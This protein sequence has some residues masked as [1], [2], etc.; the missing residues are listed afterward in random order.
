MGL[1]ETKAART[2][3]RMV[4]TALKLFE[5]TGYDATTMEQIA[6][7]AEVGTTTLYR[8]FPSKD[9]L[10]VDRLMHALDLA[11]HLRSRPADE[12]LDVSLGEVL[13]TVARAFDDP[14]QQI[15]ELRRLID[16]SVA[17]R[18]RVWDLYRAARADLEEAISERTR[19]EAGSLSVRATAG[20]AMELLQIIDETCARSN[21]Q[22]AYV[23]VAMSVLAQLPSTAI[24]LPSAVDLQGISGDSL[25]KGSLSVPGPRQG[26]TA[27]LDRLG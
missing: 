3:E 8:Y 7:L 14:L 24:V 16:D 4:N 22:R 9:L 6:E 18:A 1:R 21:Y 26:P 5:T 27:G 25:G 19:E 10:L 12:A 20:V 2:R 17:P 23:E 13:L 15:A 11:T